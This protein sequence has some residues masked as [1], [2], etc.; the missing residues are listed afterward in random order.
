MSDDPQGAYYEGRN[1]TEE[2][3]PYDEGDFQYDL[4]LCGYRDAHSDE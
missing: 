4:W 1:A 2:E 3:N